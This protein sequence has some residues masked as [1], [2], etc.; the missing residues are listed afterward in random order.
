MLMNANRQASVYSPGDSRTFILSMSDFLREF[1]P[2]NVDGLQVRACDDRELTCVR[3]PKPSVET[4][5]VVDRATG[6]IRSIRSSVGGAIVNTVHQMGTLQVD[7]AILPEAV[8]E[9]GYHQGRVTTVSI[10]SPVTV[11]VGEPLTEKDFAIPLPLGGLAMDYRARGRDRT[12]TPLR[13]S[14]ATDDVLGTLDQRAYP[15]TR[16]TSTLWLVALFV[17]L[18]VVL[19]CGWLA[20]RRR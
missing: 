3:S 20:M 8:M 11:R 16:S 13:V 10:N 2:R 19:G 12:P 9:C 15:V 4:V 14:E 6:L 5:V 18:P 17:V 7:S 1:D